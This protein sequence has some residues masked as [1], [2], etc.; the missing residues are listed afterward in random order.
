[1]ESI[2]KTKAID[3]LSRASL[4]RRI[5]IR[6][7]I[8][9]EPVISPY[10]YR[11]KQNKSVQFGSYKNESL[12]HFLSQT[13]SETKMKILDYLE[14]GDFHDIIM[15][16][17]SFCNDS[18]PIV[19]KDISPNGWLRLESLKLNLSSDYRCWPFFYML[20]TEEGKTK[21]LDYILDPKRINIEL[22]LLLNKSD[23]LHNQMNQIL[24]KEGLTTP[25]LF[26]LSPDDKAEWNALYEQ[27][28]KVSEEICKLV[29]DTDA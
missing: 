17:I 4:K 29:N 28:K 16:Y 1:M 18:S 25:D 3:I 24:L 7:L 27:S 6:R 15:Q 11:S 20:S 13:D 23:M 2:S 22:G 5:E 9:N 12:F 19:L 26:L 8:Y 10:M 21:I 14:I